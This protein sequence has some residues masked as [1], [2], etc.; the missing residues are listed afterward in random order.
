MRKFFLFFVVLT[1][2]VLCQCKSTSL[3]EEEKMVNIAGNWNIQITFTSNSCSESLPDDDTML[4]S[5]I[6]NDTILSGSTEDGDVISGTIDK[7]G[8]FNI[9]FEGDKTIS[10]EGGDM[11]IHYKVEIKGKADNET[12]LKG[13]GKS[14]M[15]GDNNTDC[16]LEFNFVAEKIIN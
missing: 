16:I 10:T 8:N 1:L 9:S 5:I 4:I 2:M 11:K 7:D 3:Q 13:T 6:Q 12:T 15:T 14:H